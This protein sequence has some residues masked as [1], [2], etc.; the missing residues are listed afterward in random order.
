MRTPLPRQMKVIMQKGIDLP[1]V[2]GL[3]D[4]IQAVCVPVSANWSYIHRVH[5]VAV[6]AFRFILDGV[7]HKTANN[8]YV[9]SLSVFIWIF[10]DVF[11]DSSSWFYIGDNNTKSSTIP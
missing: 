11:K 2:P 6:P 7:Q 9:C 3:T 5:C 10:T 4:R 1:V 8:D